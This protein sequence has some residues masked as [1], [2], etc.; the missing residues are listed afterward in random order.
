MASMTFTRKVAT[1]CGLVVAALLLLVLLYYTFDLVMLVF[2]AAL[3]AIFLAGL[4]E[5]IKPY[6]KLSDGLCVLLVSVILLAVIG[7]TIAM[8]SPSIAEQAQHL[9]AELLALV[10]DGVQ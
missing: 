3:L 1:A 2:A 7:G 4:A 5:V 6:V 10:C 8:L 9:R